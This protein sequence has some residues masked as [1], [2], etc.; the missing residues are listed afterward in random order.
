VTGRDPFA[1]KPEARAALVDALGTVPKHN[2]RRREIARVDSCA[3]SNDR[4]LS[5]RGTGPLAW[6]RPAVTVPGRSIDYRGDR[7]VDFAGLVRLTGSAS[8]PCDGRLDVALHEPVVVGGGDTSGDQVDVA[9]APRLGACEWL[10][11]QL[12]VAR[13][14]A[15]QEGD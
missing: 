5:V 8:L 9:C 13:R 12:V 6:I 4:S 10:R 15:A 2:A 1:F 7:A 14:K 3:Q 11:Q